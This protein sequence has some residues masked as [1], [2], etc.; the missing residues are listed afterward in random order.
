MYTTS[1]NISTYNSSLEKV[2][3]EHC[4]LSYCCSAPSQYN[5]LLGDQKKEVCNT[6]KIIRKKIVEIGITVVI[7]ISNF[8][9]VAWKNG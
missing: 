9:N 4:V 1:M 5:K 3:H 6:S 2:G 7:K 8:T